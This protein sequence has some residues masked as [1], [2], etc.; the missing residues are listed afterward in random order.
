MAEAPFPKLQAT[1]TIL[2]PI[3]LGLGGFFI[4]NEQ[5]KTTQY[6]QEIAQTVNAVQAMEPYIDLLA[7]GTSN[8]AKMAAYALYK[9]SPGDK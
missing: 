5:Q 6:L 3:L 2:T 4:S 1:A 9:L 8:K 7:E